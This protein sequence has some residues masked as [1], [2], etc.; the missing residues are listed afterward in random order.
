MCNPAD[1]LPPLSDFAIGRKR[2]GEW[3]HPIIVRRQTGLV[4]MVNYDGE[5][6]E[7]HQSILTRDVMP[8][9]KINCSL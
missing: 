3:K 9:P 2:G 5:T 7:P 8:P 1:N 6:G 4:V